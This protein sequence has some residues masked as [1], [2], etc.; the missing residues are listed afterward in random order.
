MVRTACSVSICVV[1]AGVPAAAQWLHQPT[2]GIPRDAEGQPKLDAPAPKLP[3]GTP[4]LS[5]YWNQPLL[6]AYLLDI[7]TDLPADAITPRASALYAQRLSE[8]GKDDPATIGCLPSG[9]RNIIGGGTAARVRIVQTPYVIAAL[10]EDLTHRQIH[11]DGRSLPD[12]PNPSFMGYSVGKWEGD[13]LVV[14]TNGFNGRTWLDFGGHP[15]GEHLKTIERWRRVSFGRIEREVTLMDGE[16]YKQPMVLQLPMTFAAD[17]DMLEYVCAENPKTRPHLVGRTEQ[18]RKVVVRPELLQ[19]YVGTYEAVGS[20][21]LGL[22]QF[23]V[24]LEND[25]LFVALNGKGR[26]RMAPM[27]DT[28]FSPRLLGTVEFMVDAS[29][30][31]THALAHRAEGTARFNR[32]R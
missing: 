2:V 1:L 15:Y 17:T 6:P 29:G 31:V 12:D 19:R 7:T 32:R 25:Q 14:E 11:L 9:P 4:D 23:T 13:T 28:T 5:G 10:F 3:D 26:I 8:F 16:F 24:S 18:E 30:V 21:E 20:L 22:R 27:S